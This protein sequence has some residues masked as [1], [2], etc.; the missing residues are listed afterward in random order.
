MVFNVEHYFSDFKISERRQLITPAGHL[1]QRKILHIYVSE[2]NICDAFLHALILAE[3]EGD[4][5]S[6]VFPLRVNGKSLHVYVNEEKIYGTFLYTLILAERG[7]DIAS[8][9]SHSMSASVREKFMAL[10]FTP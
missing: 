9:V 7:G 3:R 5:A 6:L 10:F 2:G 1:P 8:L 4:I